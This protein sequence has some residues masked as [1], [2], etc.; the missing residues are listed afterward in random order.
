M[1]HECKFE[2]KINEMHGD[3][4]VLVSEFKAMNGTLRDTKSGVEEHIKESK[5]YRTQ[6]DILWSSLHTVKW[7][8]GLLCAGGV[9]FRI[10]SGLLK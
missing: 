2:D 6:V 5:H 3:I 4:K 8:V 7:A 9:L 1:E 10:I